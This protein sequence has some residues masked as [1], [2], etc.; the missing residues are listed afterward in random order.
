MNGLSVRARGLA[1][2]FRVLRRQRTVLRALRA[3]RDPSVLRKDLLA[4]DDVS[5][6]VA[7]G[8]K[9]A[10]VGGNG[11]GKT[12]LLRI[13]TGIYERTSGELWMA[14]EARPLFSHTIGLAG[15]L[16][17][18]RNILLFGAMNSAGWA[19]M[20]IRACD[21]ACSIPASQSNGSSAKGC[22]GP[23]IPTQESFWSHF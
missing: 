20:K 11:S 1:K 17:V 19:S 4:L 13:L 9:V 14:A 15:E 16:P 2:H 6:D 3:L 21:A 8:E 12:T 22:P 5:F 23:A 7:A 18:E 10:L